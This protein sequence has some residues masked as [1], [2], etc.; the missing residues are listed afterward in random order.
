MQRLSRAKW[1]VGAASPKGSPGAEQRQGGRKWTKPV[2]LYVHFTHSAF[3]LSYV[4]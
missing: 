2:C 3:F 1:E 4:N